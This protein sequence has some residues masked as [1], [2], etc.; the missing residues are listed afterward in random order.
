MSA[1]RRGR[2]GRGRSQVSVGR[3]FAARRRE[4]GITQQ[5]ASRLLGI[6]PS[7]LSRLERGHAPLTLAV[8]RRMSEVYSTTLRSLI[9]WAG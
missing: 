4:L 8:A 9:R 5:G 3:P 6:S 2:D 1:I 7:Y